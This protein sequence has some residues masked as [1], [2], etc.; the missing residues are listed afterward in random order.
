MG[1]VEEERALKQKL[2]PHKRLQPDRSRC[3]ENVDV[4][5]NVKSSQLF[6]ETSLEIDRESN[7][8]V[9]KECNHKVEDA[10]VSILCVVAKYPGG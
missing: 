4:F 2:D 9:D 7:R 1:G 3:N 10:V 8:C 5:L 6:L